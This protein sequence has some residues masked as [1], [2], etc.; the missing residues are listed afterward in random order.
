MIENTK[1]TNHKAG[2]QIKAIRYAQDNYYYYGERV[3]SFSITKLSKTQYTEEIGSIILDPRRGV[4]TKWNREAMHHIDSVP[5]P[6]QVNG[7]ITSESEQLWL[8][9]FDGC[10]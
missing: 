1:E 3:T 2:K 7:D 4:E 10:G 6:Q 8:V 9:A 5:L